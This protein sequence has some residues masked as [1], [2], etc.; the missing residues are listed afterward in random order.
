MRYLL[1]VPFI[2]LTATATVKTKEQ[3]IEL[4]VFGSPKEI[5]ESPNKFNV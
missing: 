3:I 1:E 2:A 5:V 4:L